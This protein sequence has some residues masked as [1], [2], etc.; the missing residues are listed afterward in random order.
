MI[1]VLVLHLLWFIM[2]SISFVHIIQITESVEPCAGGDGWA[3]AEA[4][5]AEGAQSLSGAADPAGGAA[6]GGWGAGGLR[7]EGLHRGPAPRHEP[8]PAGPRHI[9][10]PP[11]DFRLPATFHAKVSFKDMLNNLPEFFP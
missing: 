5:G 8:N 4:G 3:A 6:G 1:K 9:R 7:A 2:I 10:K 11:A